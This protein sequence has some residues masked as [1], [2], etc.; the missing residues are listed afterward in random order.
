MKFR[1]QDD[2]SVQNPSRRG[3]VGGCVLTVGGVALLGTAG[4]AGSASASSKMAQSAVS[5]QQT[6][7]GKSRCDA[8]TQWQAP[9]SCKVVNGV[10]SPTGWCT[11]FAPKA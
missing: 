9:S 7:K 11:I 8:C 2:F 6:P 5:Y 4:L 10:I 3:L 1:T